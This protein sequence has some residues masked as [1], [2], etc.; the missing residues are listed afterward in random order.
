MNSDN[1]DQP[2]PE[3]L[4]FPCANIIVNELDN[5]T[6]SI[7][8]PQVAKYSF[9][10]Q[11]CIKMKRFVVIIRNL[12]KNLILYLKRFC[13]FINVHSLSIY[14][15]FNTIL[16]LSLVTRLIIY[17]KVI[18]C[19]IGSSLILFIIKTIEFLQSFRISSIQSFEMDGLENQIELHPSQNFLR[20]PVNYNPALDNLF[21]ND[22]NFM[23]MLHSN[24]RNNFSRFS[25]YNNVFNN[26]LRLRV[27]VLAM[28][29]NVM[30]HALGVIP[31]NE[32]NFNPNANNINEN[33]TGMSQ[34][35][36]DRLEFQTFGKT[37]E[38]SECT[39]CLETLIEGEEIRVLDC[40]HTFHKICI[41]KWLILQRYCPYCRALVS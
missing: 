23:H 15:C 27:H 29:M 6:I 30:L 28:R 31:E 8:M 1:N 13:Y 37:S 10:K 21:R 12:M 3:L 4:K 2:D 14:F 9:F 41:D 26:I 24:D 11:S 32:Y 35:E 16:L 40:N 36:I 38:D 5:P 39:I 18:Y 33:Q 20:R 19:W 34:E 25:E 22:H 7:P 17:H